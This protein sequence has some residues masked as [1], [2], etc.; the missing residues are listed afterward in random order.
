MDFILIVKCIGVVFFLVV[1]TV[2]L[3]L[4]L[5]IQSRPNAYNANKARTGGWLKPILGRVNTFHNGYRDFSVHAGIAVD[6]KTNSWVEQGALSDG[7]VDA[8]LKR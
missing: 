3:L 6:K 5:R 4:I 1:A 8:V 2:S 7:A